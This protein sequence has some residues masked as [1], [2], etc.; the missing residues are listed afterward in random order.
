MSEW[1]DIKEF[2]EYRRGN[3]VFSI[4]TKSEGTLINTLL[5]VHGDTWGFGFERV[6]GDNV[7]FGVIGISDVIEF[8]VELPK[9]GEE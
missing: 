6:N 3:F 9:E 5:T 2:E 8:K 7:E 4:K 1:I